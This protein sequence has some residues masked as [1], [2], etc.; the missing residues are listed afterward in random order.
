MSSDPITGVFND[1]YIS[2]AYEAYRRDPASVDES[3]RQFFR[4][5]ESLSGALPP[6]AGEAPAAARVDSDLLRKVAA[7]AKLVDAIRN[8]GHLAVPLDP[9]GT[10][11]AGTPELTPEFHG[12]AEQDLQRIPAEA[13]GGDEGATAAEV[14][15]RLR[16][17]YSS[18][19]G[20]EIAHLGNV[21]EREWLREEI[22]SGRLNAPLSEGDKRAVLQRLTEVD[23]LER[24]LGRAYQ[25]Y[26][27]FS[28][29]GGDILVPMLDV[30]IEAAATHGTREIDLAMAHRGRINVLAHTLGK[31]YATIF[32]EF[33]G[34][35]ATT[36]AV[37]ETGDVKYHLG[38]H[39]T[40][41]T[42]NGAEVDIV[43]I[44][45]PSHL[46]VVNPV[47]E[48]VA[49]ARQVMAGGGTRDESAVLPVCVH[50][51]AAFPGEGVVA[52]TFNLSGLEGFRT[53]GTLHVI[54]NNQ[55][56]FTTDPIDGRSTHYASDL[57]K[58]FEVPIIH[59]NADDAE[60]C[61]HVTRLGI[62]YRAK[63]GKDFLIDVVGY[64]RH[65]HNETDEPSFTQPELYKKIRSHPSPR[66][67]WGSR[68]VS[69]GL[70]SDADVKKLDSD[71]AANF[72]RIQTAMKSGEIHP[73]EHRAPKEGEADLSAA[74]ADTGVDAGLLRG[75]NERL[76]KWPSTLKPNPRLAKTLARRADAMGDAGG[77][78]WGHAEALAFASLLTD[79]T[80][81][82]LTGQDAERATFSHRQAVLH[83]AD[84]GEV[85][86]PLAHVA[87]GANHG[88]FEIYNSPLSEMAVLGFEYGYSTAAEDTLVLWEA[89]YG[90]FV[91]VA[92]P[93]ID[94]FIA[95]DRAKWGQDSSVVL[96]LPHGYEG[97]GPE[98]SSA[99]LERF[100]QLCAE[101][102]QRVAYPS[103]PAQYFHILRRQAALTE[104]RPLILMQPKSLLRMPEAASKLSEL[105]SG[106][107]RPVIDDPVASQTRQAIT[108]LVF[109]TG[110]IYYDLAAKRA[111]H[112][113]IVRIEELYPWPG[114]QVAQIVDL[115]PA[116]EEVIWAQEEPKNQG[117]WQYVAPR[118][119][120][121]TG[122]ALPTRYIGRPDRASPAEGYAE[123]HKKEQERIVNEVNA[124]VQQAS[125]AK[126]RGMALKS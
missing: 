18:R 34:K 40:R 74:S 98:H 123:V 65:G 64:R 100:L 28:I 118:L 35:H 5:A 81:I 10:P 83:D 109:C 57:A 110:K 88:R 21:D 16:E 63:F 7:A 41:K 111:P 6:T 39:G 30:A 106:Q 48:G 58:G 75:L 93:I 90:D 22:E 60:S 115:Y 91:N 113:A 97:Q 62:E 116:I 67:V 119:R 46:E 124:P 19:I 107:F 120:M 95:A 32:E 114:S 69:E 101:G 105:T 38:A 25:G 29:E 72:D 20:F 43:L 87:D 37:S 9:L 89:Q 99:R 108:R 84:S 8:F 112:V 55:V 102:N 4:F 117:A 1:G 33:E 125:S 31:P 23:G 47:L 53:G 66:E 73:P 121:S 27:R 59:V 15:A 96:L 103:T 52:E 44:P 13:L 79:G 92:Q 94:Q 80:S 3:W 42:A 61:V 85:Y 68:L 24:F 2:E 56:G 54:V 50:G 71:A 82:R 70:V 78:D 86:V 45:N 122:N 17:L 77:I 12:L 76:L 49:R 26:K 36:N 126:R 104:R 51:D 11:P 14:V